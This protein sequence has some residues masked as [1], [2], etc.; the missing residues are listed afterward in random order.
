MPV[1][2]QVSLYPLRQPRVSPTI[3]RAL[4]VFRSRGLEVSPGPMS[5]MVVGDEEAVFDALRETFLEASD[6]ELVMVA[7]LSN[8]CPVTAGQAASGDLPRT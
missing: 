6:G 4:A 3:D 5:T 1:A 2:A 7:T 8:A